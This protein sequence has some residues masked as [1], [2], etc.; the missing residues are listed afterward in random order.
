MS[1]E[2][3]KKPPKVPL[4]KTRYTGIYSRAGVRGTRYYLAINLGVDGSGKP[5]QRWRSFKLLG[6]ARAAQSEINDRVQ[7]G[8][9][10]EPMK[11]GLGDYVERW[12]ETR[13][14][15]RP[16][17]RAGYEMS[18]RHIRSH[19]SLAATRLGHVQ[20]EQLEDFY[21]WL[22]SPRTIDGV[23]WRGLSST[24]ILH[25]H[26]VLKQA[27]KV[28]VKRG[29]IGRDPTA[30]IESP[31]KR[32]DNPV[33]WTFAQTELF[34]S[35]VEG[36]RLEAA[37]RLAALLGL[38]R[39]EVLGL[40][41]GSLDLDRDPARIK[42][43][44]TLIGAK[45]RS[46]PKTSRGSRT[47]DLDPDTA[48]TLRERRKAQIEERLAAGP[49]W[50]DTDFVFANEVGEAPWPRTF[51]RAFDARVKEVPVPRIPLKGLR[52][53]FIS[54][55]IEEGVSPRVVQ[56]IVGHA[57]IQTTLGSYTATSPPMVA[58]ATEDLAQRV[59]KRSGARKAG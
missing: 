31:K 16:S 14:N 48:D 49:V 33:A 22:E 12:L 54:K 55:M 4:E 56:V 44:Q 11:M 9:Y 25:I 13:K 39:G 40:T 58:R 8:T 1:T 42:I 45:E 2:T 32:P 50:E 27:L 47:L 59:G 10:I 36:D 20:P 38:R 21:K 53:T 28:A 7:K 19:P 52:S 5:Q 17:T 34:L 46:T 35:H 3:K 41:W 6:E 57:H 29:H 23:E 37:Y 51:S 18:V 26:T 15:I 30:L 24:S 43:T